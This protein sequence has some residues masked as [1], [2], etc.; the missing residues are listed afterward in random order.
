MSAKQESEPWFILHDDKQIIN[1]EHVLPRKPDGNW[2]QFSEEDVARLANRLGN[3]AL[4]R[5]SDNSALGSQAF[6]EKRAVYR[7]SPYVLT[8][9]IA[10]EASWTEKAINARQ[11]TMANLAATTWSIKA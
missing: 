4:M 6:S 10:D 8:S 9:Q 5:A 7:A 1:L 2:K 3:L 11:I